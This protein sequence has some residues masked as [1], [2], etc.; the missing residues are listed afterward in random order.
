MP[1]ACVRITPDTAPTWIQRISSSGVSLFSNSA[2]KPPM[3]EPQ[4][5][6]PESPI[7]SPLVTTER[8]P[9]KPQSTLG[10]PPQTIGEQRALPVQPERTKRASGR[11]AGHAA[12][13]RS[14]TGAGRGCAAPLPV[15]PSAARASSGVYSPKSS[16]QPS[17]PSATASRSRRP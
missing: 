17:W 10:S 7:V 13:R 15:G 8:R 5:L 12:A 6:T 4:V 14:G 3:S 1:L 2:K 16:I 9:S 11:G